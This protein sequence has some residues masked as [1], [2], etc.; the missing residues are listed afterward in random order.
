MWSVLDKWVVELPFSTEAEKI[1]AG[2]LFLEGGLMQSM[3]CKTYVDG[4]P[5]VSHP[6]L[7]CV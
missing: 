3:F 1:R 5:E 6:L 4:M 7:C 2:E